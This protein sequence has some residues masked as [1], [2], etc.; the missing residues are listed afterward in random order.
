MAPLLPAN[1]NGLL[2]G[3]ALVPGDVALAAGVGDLP[4]LGIFE[5][6]SSIA[7]NGVDVAL[8]VE[9]E[10]LVVDD[11]LT[12]LDDVLDHLVAPGALLLELE[13]QTTLVHPNAKVTIFFVGYNAGQQLPHRV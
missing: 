5:I 12:A 1:C 7:G 13:H 3:L 8:L 9:D 4:V 6:G 2:E 10:L 11:L